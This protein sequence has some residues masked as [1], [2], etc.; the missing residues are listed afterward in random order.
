MNEYPVR[1]NEQL[2]VTICDLT[3]EGLGVAKV[4]H[5]PL[6]IENAL[7]GEQVTAQVLKVGKN[8][9][10]AKVLTRQTTSPDRVPMHDQAL[11][12]TGIA[13][14]QHMTYG[15]QLLFKQSQVQ[16]VL[17]KIGGL[18]DIPVLPTLGMAQPQGYR[19]KAQIPVRM[20][21]GQLEVGFYRKNSH[22]LVPIEDFYIQDPAIDRALLVIREL[23]RRFQIVPYDEQNHTGS[24][25][26]LMIRRGY[27]SHEMMIVFVTKTKKLHAKTELVQAIV[28]ALPETVSILQS[29][30]PEKTNVILGK[31]ITVLYGKAFIEDQLLGKTYRISAPSFYQVNTL[32]T[33]ALYQ[34]AL[35]FANVGQQD[36]IIDA[37]CGIGTIGLS[38]AQRVKH[39]YG[40]DIVPEAIEDAKKNA[41]RNHITNTTWVAD[42]AEQAMAKWQQDGLKPKVIL[43][44]PPRKGLTPSFIQAALKMAPEQIIYISCNPATLARDLKLFTQDAPYRVEKV[45]PVDLFPQTFHVETVCLL[46]RTEK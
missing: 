34:I 31:H 8:F 32:Q 13:P 22:Q 36:C 21:N 40:V 2:E 15:A 19:N 25:R 11:L 1:K 10:Y 17:K 33:E 16:N 42:Q 12:R 5:Y 37:Y 26:H 30:Q 6:F 20:L 46:T 43:V 7:P 23:L 29:Y 18:S 24:L 4:A 9:G 44:D 41:Q 35:A 28:Q 3:H 38:F 45:Q 14:L 39:V 27:Y